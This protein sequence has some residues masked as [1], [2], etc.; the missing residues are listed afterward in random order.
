MTAAD[1]GTV[2][3]LTVIATGLYAYVTAIAAV[4]VAS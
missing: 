4:V 2:A 1:T 3:L